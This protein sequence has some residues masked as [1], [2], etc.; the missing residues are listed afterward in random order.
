MAV[1]GGCVPLLIAVCFGG[2]RGGTDLRD[3][4]GAADRMD[5]RYSR[6]GI[7]ADLAA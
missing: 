2:R 7:A 6:H 5:I 1:Y 4:A 3:V